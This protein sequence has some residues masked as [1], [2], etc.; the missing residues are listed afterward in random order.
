MFLPWINVLCSLAVGIAI[1]EE[2]L[3][4]GILDIILYFKLDRAIGINISIV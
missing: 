2:N 1:I 4:T 3:S